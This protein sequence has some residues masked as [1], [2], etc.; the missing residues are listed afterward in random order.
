[1]SPLKPS[2][3]VWYTMLDHLFQQ[4]V[5]SLWKLCSLFLN[6]VG[7]RA[8]YSILCYIQ[9]SCYQNSLFQVGIGTE[10]W[11]AKQQETNRTGPQVQSGCSYLYSAKYHLQP[12]ED[13]SQKS[14]WLHVRQ[15][16]FLCINF[17]HLCWHI[18]WK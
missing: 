7:L 9:R 6:L 5:I 17:Y 13:S 14:C 11:R 8:F 18:L 15:Q 1:M 12:W 2:R 4:S 3:H 16:T 10:M